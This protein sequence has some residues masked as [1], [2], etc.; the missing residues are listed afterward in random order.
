MDG[1]TCITCALRFTTS[2]L[3]RDHF[4][5]EHHRFNL[6][7]KVLE[8]PPVTE[9]QFQAK[10]DALAA[11][12]TKGNKSRAKRESKMPVSKEDRVQVELPTKEET[13]TQKTTSHTTAQTTTQPATTEPKD[14]IDAYIE[15][16][17]KD[18]KP[19]SINDCLFC[20]ESSSSLD[21]NIDHMT[22]VH[23]FFIPDIEYMVDLEGFIKYLEEKVV[24]GNICLYCNGKG[25]GL[26]SL[27]AVQ[28]HMRDL[29]HC[30]LPLEDD[31]EFDDY[32]DF[33]K[34]YPDDE[35]ADPDSELSVEG[36]VSVA[37][38]G[39]E[40]VF[41]DGRVAAHRSVAMYY[42][43]NVK[44]PETRYA[45]LVN[46][47]MAQYKA[48]GWTSGRQKAASSNEVDVKAQ[49][50]QKL[51]HMRLGVKSNRL[52]KHYRQQVDF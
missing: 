15:Q 37:D 4:R 25:R 22:K 32:Y 9:E 45:F 6:K 20:A 8:L 50:Q 18:A 1:F 33:S 43:Q 51:Q 10:V 35:E 27:E 34:S 31:G 13:T 12:P 36:R 24:I 17:L 40:L 14:E 19:V 11:Q 30:K 38:N 48:L 49:R 26:H 41:K 5:S 46:S 3:Q 39:C 44:P 16:K 42:K 2:Q 23:S 47:L 28:S 7:R 29:S 21:E 52:Q